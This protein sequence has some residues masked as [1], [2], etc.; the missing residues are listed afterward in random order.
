MGPKS[1]AERAAQRVWEQARREFESLGEEWNGY[2]VDV[3]LLA[4]L[5]FALGVQPVNDLRVGDREYA[6]FLDG[7]GKLIAVEGRHHPHRQRFSI[8]HEVG[9]YVLHYRPNMGLFTCSSRDMEVSASAL[10]GPAPGLQP[11]PSRPDSPAGQARQVPRFLPPGRAGRDPRLLHLQ[12]EYEANLFASELLMPEQPVRAMY[13][14]TGGKL[15]ALARHFD[16]SAQA[17][18]IRLERLGLVARR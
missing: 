12:R 5:L 18:E 7:D 16:V 10:Q 2:R 15:F 17:M 9:H 4:A 6:A 11:G 13:R 14:V 8:A 1:P 3:E